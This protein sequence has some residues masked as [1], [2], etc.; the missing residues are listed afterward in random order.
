MALV[1]NRYNFI[2]IKNRKVAS[3]SVEAFFEKYCVDPKK[4]VNYSHSVKFQKSKF[5]IVGGR[6]DHSPNGKWDGHQNAT[7]IKRNLGEKKFDKYFKFCVVRNP[8]DRMVSMYYWMIGGSTNKLGVISFEEFIR[9]IPIK[10]ENKAKRWEMYLNFEDIYSINNKSVCDEYI[11]FENLEEGIVRVCEKLGIT[12]Y[13]IKEL[14]KFKV[15]LRNK[16]TGKHYREYY[17]EETQQ[18]VETL[19]REEIKLFGYEF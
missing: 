1:S 15:G 9:K 14:P 17:N 12:D 5:G 4:K 6:W 2:Y 13:N 10:R 11:R 8:W 3:T 18:I 7:N 19:H 16:P